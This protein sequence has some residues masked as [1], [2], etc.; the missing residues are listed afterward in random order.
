M[1][2]VISKNWTKS[3]KA[4]WEEYIQAFDCRADAEDYLNNRKICD[5]HNDIFN[6]EFVIQEYELVQ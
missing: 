5:E 2:M 4:M 6:R 3:R 1:Y